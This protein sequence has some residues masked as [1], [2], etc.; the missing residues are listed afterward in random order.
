M[1]QNGCYLTNNTTGEYVYFGDFSINVARYRVQFNSYPFPY[2]SGAA[3]TA[4]GYSSGSGINYTGAAQNGVSWTIPS[5]LYTFFGIVSSAATY[6][7]PSTLSTSVSTSELPTLP[8]NYLVNQVILV[9][10]SVANNRRN[11]ISFRDASGTIQGH[12]ATTV[13]TS[14]QVTGAFGTDI[15]G[16]QFTT[17]WIPLLESNSSTLKF[18]LTNQELQDLVLEDDS[19][20]VEFLITSTIS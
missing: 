2:V 12:G 10:C 18:W 3:A 7:I 6:S 11:A 14:V 4:A 8:P 17:T 9:H 13:I 19:V 1:I 5:A 16:D 15:H 20:V